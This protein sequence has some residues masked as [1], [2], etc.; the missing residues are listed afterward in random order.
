MTREWW[1]VLL[2][3]LIASICLTAAAAESALALPEDLTVIG[4]EAFRGDTDIAQIDLPAG[5]TEIG[6]GAFRD[7]GR[8]GSALKYYFAPAGITVGAGAF[9]NCRAVLKWNGTELPHLTYTISGGSVTITSVTG[10]P[11]GVVIPDTIEGKPVTAIGSGAFRDK[12]AMTS[13]T[14]PSGVRSIGSDAFRGCTALTGLQLPSGLTSLGLR[15][16]MDCRGLAQIRIPSGISDIP[17]QAFSG[18]QNLL[19]ANL[20]DG[21]I[22]IGENAFYDCYALTQADIPST[23]VSIGTKAFSHNQALPRVI[24]PDGLESLGTEVFY[25]C[26]SLVS[27]HLPGS[28]TAIGDYLFSGC[29]KLTE[30]NFPSG[31]TSIGRDAFSGACVNQPGH[32]VYA[33]PEGLEA[34]GSGAFNNCGAALCVVRN[35]NAE[36]LIR[37]SGCTLT[38]Y[39]RLDFRYRY[40]S[41]GGSYQLCL[42]GYAGQGGRVEIP[43]GPV[44]IGESAFADNAAITAV[45][46]PQGVTG[47]ERSAFEGCGNLTSAVIPGG[48]T[49]I[50][51]NAFRNCSKLID[52]SFPGTLTEIGA[53][54]FDH[55]CY[56]QAGTHYFDLP[57]GVTTLGWTPFTDCGA[58]LRFNRDSGA[59]ALFRENQYIYTYTGESDFRYRWYASEGERLVSYTG[60]D[61]DAV[62]IPDHIWL[63]DDGA[64]RGHTEIRLISIPEGVTRINAN[65]FRDCANLT[66][67]HLPQTLNELRDN[68]FYGCGDAADE[69][70]TL[71]LPADIATVGPGA[72]TG[73]HMIPVCDWASTTASVISNRGYSFVRADRAFETEFRYKYGYDD[74]VWVPRLYDYTGPLGSVLLPEDCA[75]VDSTV[76]S[77]KTA[78]GLELV[79]AQL[80]ETA[81]G[82][83]NA[84][85]AFTF[86]GHEGLRY[87]IIDGVLYVM[88]YQGDGTAVRIPQAQAYINAGWDEQIRAGAF[89][90]D[91]ALTQVSIPEGVTCI[92]ADAFSGCVNLTDIALPGSLKSIDQ[93]AFR[94]CGRDLPSPFYLTL[95]D[96]LQD[97]MGRNGGSNTFEDTNAV[98]VCGKTSQ[99][100]A[101]LS[102]RNYVY[103]CPGETDFRYRYETYPS[104]SEAGRQLWLV[105]YEGTDATAE[106]PSG[107]YGI[108]RFDPNTTAANWPTFHGWGFCNNTV[109]TKVVIPEGTVVIEDSAFLGCVD[110]TDITFPESL[111]VL[112]NHAFEQCGKNSNELHYYVLPDD[113]TE[114]STNVDSGWGAFT[115][116]NMGRI[117]CDPNGSTALQLSGIDTYNHGGS[118]LFAL[119]GHEADGLLYRIDRFASSVQGETDNRLVLKKYEGAQT[120]VEIPSGT[121]LYRIE[122]GAFKDAAVLEKVILPG[123]LVE[124]GASAFDGC[125]RLHDGAEQNAIVIPE[126]VQRAES[127][128]FQNLGAAWTSERFFLVLP[129]SLSEFDINIFNGCNAVLVA[130][131]GSPVARALYDNWYYYYTSLED[132]RAQDDLQFQRYYVDGVEAPHVHYGR[133]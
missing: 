63:I 130:P 88:G 59:A 50:S 23:V 58:V 26:R 69:D 76:L 7:C 109:V 102:D 122:S 14:I 27:V 35:G 83:S 70:F 97:L 45:T 89:S 8:P 71:E 19:T 105:G 133:Q 3:A 43:V 112:K 11:T 94:Y 9:E 80:S 128:A 41:V 4:A 66:A 30:I 113:M 131:A 127:L 115:D 54:A 77:A 18:C 62:T 10:Q 13:L 101:L 72:L 116:I 57:D 32:P 79:C 129:G 121:G 118:Y 126:F 37:E 92:N 20:P 56:D 46:I 6:A 125:E 28:L 85:L 64:F 16:F 87:R 81:Q 90:G 24:L 40:R 34:L 53:D 22:S 117:A 119:K 36:A 96:D 84:G 15:A 107:I 5:V 17:A 114:I 29:T 2:W 103:T 123:G 75:H 110:L 47:I 68:A 39:D 99:T 104:G 78:N 82:L 25:D 55:T 132:A 31:L 61:S 51:N 60:T 95:P 106:I 98:L 100:A 52:V 124:I 120:E 48:V 91:E 49:A 86:P 42:T 12:S 67:I 33:L 74:H 93:K 44:V 21:L 1:T 38:Y 111:K 73:G 108:R 65:A